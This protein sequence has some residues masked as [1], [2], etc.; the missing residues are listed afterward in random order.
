MDCFGTNW[1]KIFS[2]VRIEILTRNYVTV[3]SEYIIGLVNIY[4]LTLRI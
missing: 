2:R 4:S 1:L 3:E